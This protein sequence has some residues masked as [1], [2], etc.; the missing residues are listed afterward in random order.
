MMNPLGIYPIMT[1]QENGLKAEENIRVG[2][3]NF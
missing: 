2:A 3:K 1:P